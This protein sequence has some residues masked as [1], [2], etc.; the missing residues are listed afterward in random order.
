MIHIPGVTDN[1][2][3]SNAL[4]E[5]LDIFPTLVEAAGL[6]PLS[7]CPATSNNVHLCT[8][9]LSMLPL[10]ADPESA[11]WK[12]EV[13]WQ[14]PRGGWY[15]GTHI[16]K[17]MGYSLRNGQYR[18]T[19]WPKIKLLGAGGYLPDWEEEHCDHGELYDLKIDPQEN[20]NLIFDPVFVETVKSLRKVLRNN[21]SR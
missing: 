5:L 14:Y 4:T 12:S 17:C 21:H 8:E 20:S 18:Y 1:G 15:E 3:R 6:P 9:G 2:V 11:S 16:P 7:K 10:I 19:E 13:F